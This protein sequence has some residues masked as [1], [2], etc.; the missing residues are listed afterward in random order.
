[1][2][3]SLSNEELPNENLSDKQN[4][5]M[6]LFE[7]TLNE[8]IETMEANPRLA[9]SVRLTEKG[10]DNYDRYTREEALFLTKATLNQPK[11]WLLSKDI[12]LCRTLLDFT[13]GKES[14][15]Y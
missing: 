14:F 5:E 3:Q 6:Q 13:K 11:L 12:D 7:S 4:L 1:M 9:G 2:L 15:L 10:Y 8:L